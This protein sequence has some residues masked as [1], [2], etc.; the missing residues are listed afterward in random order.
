MWENADAAGMSKFDVIDA[1]DIAD[2]RWNNLLKL[3][4]AIK[5]VILLSIIYVLLDPPTNTTYK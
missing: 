1:A 3:L 2:M 4:R 5:E